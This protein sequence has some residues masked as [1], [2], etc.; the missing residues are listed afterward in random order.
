M[1]D[2][3]TLDGGNQQKYGYSARAIMAIHKHFAGLPF[4][5][6]Q[7]LQQM[8]GLPISASTIFDQNE[9]TANDL[10]PVFKALMALSANAIHY[11]NDDTTNR[12]LNQGPIQKPDRRSGQ[13]KERSGIYTS[14]VI[15]TLADGR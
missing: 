13:L 3:V 9:A 10:Q 11:H 6:Q 7:T 1:P 4:Y 5:R 15:A 14:G 12:I 8:F 2:E